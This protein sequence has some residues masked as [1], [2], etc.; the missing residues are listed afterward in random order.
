MCCS[1][2]QGQLGTNT[3]TANITLNVTDINEFA[4]VAADDTVSL[5]EN[6]AN[7]TSV[8]TVI[9]QIMIRQIR[10]HIQ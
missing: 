6:A 1:T 8:H 9:E 4:P 3:D 5:A 7:G 10:L 2:V